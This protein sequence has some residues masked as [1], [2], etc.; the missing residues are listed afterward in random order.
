[1]AVHLGL[2]NPLAVLAVPCLSVLKL[3]VTTFLPTSLTATDTV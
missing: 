1:M 2:I 3:T